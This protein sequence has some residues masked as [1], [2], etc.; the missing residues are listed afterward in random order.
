MMV[1]SAKIPYKKALNVIKIKTICTLNVNFFCTLPNLE[2][3]YIFYISIKNN[4]GRYLLYQDQWVGSAY[5]FFK[6]FEET[7][8][9]YPSGIMCNVD[10]ILAHTVFST[11][12]TE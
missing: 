4:F 7:L 6:K 9:H 1:G 12:M 10:C 5:R 8:S 2:N 11:T 3:L